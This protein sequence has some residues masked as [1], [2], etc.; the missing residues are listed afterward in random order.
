VHIVPFFDLH[1]Q[2]SALSTDIKKAIDGVLASSQ[3]VLG[4]EVEAFEAEFA[5][6]CG[7]SH[8]ISVGNGLDALVLLLRALNIGPGDE[9]LVPAHTFVATWLAVAQAGATPVGIDVGEDFTIA[10]T[11]LEAAITPRTRAIMPVH[12]YGQPADM[13]SINAVAARHSLAVLE[14]AAQA[15]GAAFQGRSAGAL[16]LAAGFSFYPTKNLGALGDGG[17]VTTNDPQLAARIRRLRNYGS[18][19]KYVHVEQ[20]INSRLDEIQAAV[21]RVKLRHLAAHNTRRRALATR[22]HEAL[23]GLPITA[24]HMQPEREHVWHLY[25]IRTAF[26]ADLAAH[27]HREGI[28]SLIHYPI[29]PHLQEA[30]AGLGYRPGAFPVAERM[31]AEVLS[32]PFWPEMDPVLI[33]RVAA[34]VASFV[35]ESAG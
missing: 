34:A 7:V 18:D 26:R 35:P 1:A 32:L 28:G 5:A 4:P 19:V 11:A 31:A 27:L 9:V 24:P 20:G 3:L 15:H 25:V 10:P 13:Q 33:E 12:L 16:G 8:C 14:D 23:A 17:A 30:M 2:H 21:L 6:F 29:P 22:Y